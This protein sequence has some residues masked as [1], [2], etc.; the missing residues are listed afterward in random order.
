[1]ISKKFI[2]FFLV[3]MVFQYILLISEWIPY[4]NMYSD[5]Q[6][7]KY[8][9]FKSQD[10]KLKLN[11]LI[12]MT[13]GYPCYLFT[14]YKIIGEKLFSINFISFLVVILTYFMWDV[15]YYSMLENAT[16]HYLVLLYDVFIVGGLC[17]VLTQFIFNKYY[18][19]LEKNIPIVGLLY[20]VGIFSFVYVSFKYNPDISNITG[21]YKPF[22]SLFFILFISVASYI[23]I[24]LK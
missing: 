14:I 1:M 18:K 16:N 17:L 10:N 7:Y 15:A 20:I 12:I 19:I 11:P 3:F 8:N 4:L 9:W 24:K 23:L 22:H 2:I 13:I 6:G 5:I 21:I